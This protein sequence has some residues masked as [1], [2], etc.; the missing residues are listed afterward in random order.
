MMAQKGVECGF[1]Q[2]PGQGAQNHL[3]GLVG[4]AVS[5]KAD[6]ILYP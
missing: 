3:N 5:D 1:E 4:M 6:L 2:N